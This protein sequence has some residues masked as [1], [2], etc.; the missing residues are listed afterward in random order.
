MVKT[1]GRAGV[2]AVTGG[3]GGHVFPALA[4]CEEC[5]R[6]GAGPA[7]VTLVVALK[8]RG[9]ADAKLREMLRLS[10]VDTIVLDAARSIPG[11]LR[12]FFTS[13]FLLRRVRPEA[14]IGFGGY[15]CVPF[16]WWA[17]L[18]G[19]RTFL[20]EQ[21]VIPGQANR[22]AGL[23]VSRIA[24]TFEASVM[25]FARRRRVIL[26]RFPLRASLRR[27][28]REE[29]ERALGLQPGL[30]NVLVMGGSQGARRLNDLF[31]AALKE[32][33]DL[34]G[35]QVVHL[36][37]EKQAA[38]VEGAYDRLGVPHRVLG[39][40][41]D[42]HQAYSAADLVVSRAGAG[43]V[44]E[45][46]YFGLPSILVPYPHAAGHQTGNARVLAEAGAAF[47]IEESRWTAEMFNGLLDILRHD[48]M[49]RKTMAY[50]AT[51]L[52]HSSS[53]R[54]LSEAVLL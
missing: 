31:A 45:L 26:T 42:I 32:N 21:N 7:A 50:I 9:A 25:Y 36:S 43:A 17:W 46:M 8:G 29:A 12:L 5:G 11:L 54:S 41:A 28:S 20:H 51:G 48:S 14:V 39:F 44:M 53:R 19:R 16:L 37:G 13:F 24:V 1:Q 23:F 27:L 35:L 47:L 18:T 4:F 34:A 10:G 15:A 3:S 40:L 2:L 6:Q 49:R 30:V 38:E 52:Y 22:L 33:R